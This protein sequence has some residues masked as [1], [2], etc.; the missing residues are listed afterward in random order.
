M[1]VGILAAALVLTAPA[2]AVAQG[3]LLDMGKAVLQQKVGGTGGTTSSSNSG[4]LGAALS[5]SDIASGLKEALRQGSAAVTQRLGQADGFN[6]DPKVH[7]PLPDSLRSVQSALKM[8]GMSGLADDLELKLNRAA[9]AATPKAKQIFTSALEKMT[10]DDARAILNGPK[11]SATQYF[12]KAMTPDLKTAFR[13]V[14]DKTVA[15]AGA[16]KSFETLT[17]SAKGLPMVGDARSMLTDHVLDGAL[18]GIFA[19]L[20]EE[21]AAIRD[22]PAKRG[23]E[24]LRK[25]FGN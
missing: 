1:R 20:A 6:A 14:I 17:S 9:E 7:I 24:L 5:T 13:P 10:L 25:V 15:E 2:I 16:V 4:G 3:S 18:S 23:S 19:Y 22:N 8:T 11:D 12:K 21:E